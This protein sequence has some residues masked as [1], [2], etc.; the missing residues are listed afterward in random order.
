L[1]IDRFA[2]DWPA[3]ANFFL[4]LGPAVLQTILVPLLFAYHNNALLTAPGVMNAE[5]HAFLL[6]ASSSLRSEAAEAKLCGLR[7]P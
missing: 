7:F 4:S 2:E 1:R 5:F 6:V 3:A